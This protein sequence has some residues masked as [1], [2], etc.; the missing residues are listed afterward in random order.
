LRLVLERK[1]AARI[2]SDCSMDTGHSPRRG[3]RH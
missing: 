2:L 3:Y 1:S